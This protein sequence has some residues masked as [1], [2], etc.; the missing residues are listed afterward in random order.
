MFET[1]AS[2]PAAAAMLQRA[3]RAVDELALA[4]DPRGRLPLVVSGSIG[5]RLALRLQAGVRSRLVPARG[6]AALG[7]LTLLQQPEEA[8]EEAL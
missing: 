4:I 1:E 5:E 6:G 3:T 7:A 2:D 8:M